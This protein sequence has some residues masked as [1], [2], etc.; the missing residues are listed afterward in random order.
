MRRFA[1]LIYAPLLLI[2]AVSLACSLFSPAPGPTS[3]PS[4]AAPSPADTAVPPAPVQTLKGKIA[5]SSERNGNWQ[6]MAM[7]A[8][9][10]DETSLTGELGAYARPSWSPDGNRIGMRMDITSGTG[11]AVM[12]VRHENGKLTGSQ[13]IAVANA[14]ADGPRW[15][16][17]G[18]RLV[19]SATRNDSGG[20]LTFIADLASGTTQQITAIPEH[21]TD[22][23]WSPDGS[24]IIFASY[25]DSSRQIR[26]LFVVNVDGTGLVQLTNTP[27]TNESA[28]AWSPD[29]SMIAFAAYEDRQESS[30]RQDLFI[31]N[32]DGSGIRQLTTDPAGDF[33]PA[34]SPDG[35]QLAF[36]S[37]R[38]ANNDN[39]YEIYLIHADGSG[40]MR[41]TNN[42]Y[43]DRW[44]AWRAERPEDGPAAAC[45]PG[46]AAAADI[47][48]PPGTRF[49]A[50]QDF[51]KVWRLKNTGTCTWTPG[52]YRLRF[53]EGEQMGPA[54][55]IPVPG[56]IQPDTLADFVL[57][58][59]VPQEP[60]L[61]A[62][63]W[64]LF[65]G[66]G[67]PVPGA[68]GNPVSLVVQIQLVQPDPS[69]LPQPLYFVAG[70]RETAQLWRMETDAH[71]VT[72]VTNGPD[73][74][75]AFD[76]APD[77]RVAYI[78]QDHV[79]VTDSMGGS[80][81]AVASL[82][83]AERRNG[84]AWSPDGSKLA[85][86]LGGI[87][88]HDLSSGE[89]VMLVANKQGNKP[90]MDVYEPVEWSPD[91][92][93]L[94]ARVYLWEGMAARILS[95]SDGS[96]LVEFPMEQSAWAADSTSVY[97][98]SHSLPEFMPG[99]PGMWRVAAGGAQ[100]E[101]VISNANTW[102][103]T[104]ASDGSLLFFMH[105]PEL[106][107]GPDFTV[108]PFRLDASGAQ[109]ALLNSPGLILHPNDTFIV[110][111]TPDASRYLAQI[112]RPSLHVSEI[113]LYDPDGSPP[114]LFLMHQAGQFEWGR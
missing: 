44:P 74:V 110:R 36:V 63:R 101:K 40:E 51:S 86:S 56:A 69:L 98:A 24:R 113:L 37:D 112:V 7:N 3:A 58:L 15:S 6:I 95:V 45:Q 100:P 70:T 65:D 105:P 72:Q 66:E 81:Q 103:P 5:F 13:P 75:L 26:D 114:P 23:D 93:K 85:Y 78:A 43:T 32:S 99:E 59:T 8:D 47:T 71:T 79:I 54:S 33:D 25:T 109:P 97:Y 19:Y 61:H 73:P 76:I 104:V 108:F 39:N 107:A 90:G 80:R 21:A 9:G 91:G 102:W 55:E 53:V 16:P 94:L 64:Q 111:W 62:G 29:G 82:E 57:P 27:T 83:D 1:R 31:M 2:S 18:K 67:K 50:P 12:D 49:T 17:D 88:L 92:T 11:I 46:I 10:S 20:W 42:R 30:P 34:W 41:L 68:D 77:G 48:I 60:G 35:T 89:D 84:L 28:P 87:R 22:P 106:T 96:V 14:F 4:P 38:D 52:A